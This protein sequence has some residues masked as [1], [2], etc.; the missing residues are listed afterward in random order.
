MISQTTYLRIIAPL[1]EIRK[2]VLIQDESLIC[3]D[4]TYSLSL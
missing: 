4:K 1:G 3:D 2:G